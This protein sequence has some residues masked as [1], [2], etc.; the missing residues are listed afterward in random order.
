MLLNIHTK[1]ILTTEIGIFIGKFYHVKDEIIPMLQHQFFQKN[2]EG[3]SHSQL[4][5]WGLNNA[6]LAPLNASASMENEATGVCSSTET[7]IELAKT[8]ATRTLIR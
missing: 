4:L 7:T 1:Y 2:G 6:L 3:N 5:L 8:F